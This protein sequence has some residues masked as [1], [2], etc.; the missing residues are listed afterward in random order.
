MA[1]VLWQS[2]IPTGLYERA[3]FAVWTPGGRI[4]YGIFSGSPQQLSGDRVAPAS[5]R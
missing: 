4:L 3:D 5:N 1:G 2:V